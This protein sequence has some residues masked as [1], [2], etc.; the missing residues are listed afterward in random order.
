MNSGGASPPRKAGGGCPVGRPAA[1]PPTSGGD[2]SEDGAGGIRLRDRLVDPLAPAPGG[3]GG[4]GFQQAVAIDG[5]GRYLPD[6]GCVRPGREQGP[7][8]SHGCDALFA[9]HAATARQA[10][11]C[12]PACRGRARR[13]PSAVPAPRARMPLRLGSEADVRVRPARRAA[14][15]VPGPGPWGAPDTP[16]TVRRTPRGPGCGERSTRS[17]VPGAG[18]LAAPGLSS[19]RDPSPRPERGPGPGGGAAGVPL[20][21]P[22]GRGRA[23]P[24]APPGTA[25]FPE[26]LSHR[27][28]TSSGGGSG[29]GVRGWVPG[30]VT[31]GEGEPG[32]SPRGVRGRKALGPAPGGLRSEE[33]PPGPGPGRRPVSGRGGTR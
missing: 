8:A 28:R 21:D 1:G 25:P 19:T 14:V 11:P 29:G 30:P 33:G 31:G 9:V 10:G 4:A 15:T 13:G 32:P 17:T 22:S 6:P 27:R 26:A 5:A 24:S 23:P 20:P 16:P 12:R 2:R 18:R 3:A 7:D